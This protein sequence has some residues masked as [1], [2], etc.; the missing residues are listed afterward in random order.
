MKQPKNML[1]DLVV[2]RWEK[3]STSI[4]ATLVGASE[5][6]FLALSHPRQLRGP[7][8]AGLGL[9]ATFA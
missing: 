1:G 9:Q 8:A 6:S 2:G 5:I 4:V 7:A 3:N